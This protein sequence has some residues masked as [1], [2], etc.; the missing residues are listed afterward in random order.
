MVS[1][2]TPSPEVTLAFFYFPH[3]KTNSRNLVYFLFET[4]M[5]FGE[6]GRDDIGGN[7]HTHPARFPLSFSPFKTSMSSSAHPGPPTSPYNTNNGLFNAFLLSTTSSRHCL[8]STRWRV[9]L[10]SN[11]WRT[12][13]LSCESLLFRLF[14]VSSYTKLK[15]T[16]IQ[17][18]HSLGTG[19]PFHRDINFVTK[20]PDPDLALTD[21]TD[22]TK[23]CTEGITLAKQPLGPH[24]AR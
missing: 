6:N 23:N 7:L 1:I 4:D 16:K 3:Y 22:P 13:W 9:E 14:L 20:V 18:C 15:Q 5:W 2:G 21:F 24:V 8:N 11:T 17:W 10:G 12:F 19:D